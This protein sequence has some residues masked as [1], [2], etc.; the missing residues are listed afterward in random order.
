MLPSA[1]RAMTQSVVPDLTY[2]LSNQT[3][4][5]DV[6]L[7]IRLTMSTKSHSKFPFRGTYEDEKILKRVTEE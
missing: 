4:T 3:L 2:I 1:S 7:K 6:K 5:Y